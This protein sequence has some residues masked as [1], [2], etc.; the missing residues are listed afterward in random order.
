VLAHNAAVRGAD[1]LTRALARERAPG[2]LEDKVK[3]PALLG[4]AALMFQ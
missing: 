4:D 1:P 3:A 2:A